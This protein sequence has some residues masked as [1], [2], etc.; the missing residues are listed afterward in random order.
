M[1]LHT[2]LTDYTEIELNPLYSQSGEK[3][4]APRHSLP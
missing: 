1:A 3:G 2:K 4:H